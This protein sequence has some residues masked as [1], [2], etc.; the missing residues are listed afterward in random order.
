MSVTSLVE[1][2]VARTLQDAQTALSHKAL[3]ELLT[4][5]ADR[6]SQEAHAADMS[7]PTGQCCSCEL[8]MNGQ[9][10]AF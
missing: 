5:L 9:F 8:C 2:I 3:R 7:Q 1:S 6:F 4:N 10:P